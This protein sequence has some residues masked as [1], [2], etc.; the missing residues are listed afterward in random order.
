MKKSTAVRRQ[1]L[2]DGATLN[3]SFL[4]PGDRVAV[5]CAVTGHLGQPQ[6]LLGYART[7]DGLS[8]YVAGPAG[9]G[10]RSAA[11]HAADFVRETL[12]G[13]TPT[14]LTELV[15]DDYAAGDLVRFVRPAA[16]ELLAA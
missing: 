6:Q 4:M 16:A 15:V 7:P 8:L 11:E 10:L 2:P 14:H 13:P 5:R 3:L 12:F 1:L 9:W